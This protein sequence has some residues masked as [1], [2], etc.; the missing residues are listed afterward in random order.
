MNVHHLTR[1]VAAAAATALFL[2][3]T[4]VSPVFADAK[5]PYVIGAVLT[6]SG[7]GANLGKPSAEAL[8]ILAKHTN[9]AG[10]VKGHPVE[11]RILDDNGDSTRTVAALR[12]LA[13]DP[14]VLAIIGPNQSPN[15]LA[16]KPV[17]A[18]EHVPLFALASS[19]V[20]SHPV[21]EWVFQM[22]VPMP[23]HMVA[24]YDDM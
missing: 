1:R 7:S 8:Q 18:D 22:P 15:A 13:A 20:I 10:G 6:L 3:G 4:G 11:I 19:P 16:A 12:Q 2:A 17:A 24:L 21:S 9:D 14:K 5:N 23:M